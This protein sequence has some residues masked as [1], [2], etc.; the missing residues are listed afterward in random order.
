[1][2]LALDHAPILIIWS[3]ELVSFPTLDGW[4][5]KNNIDTDTYSEERK[6]DTEHPI[7]NWEWSGSLLAVPLQE[8]IHWWNRQIRD[9]NAFETSHRVAR[10]LRDIVWVHEVCQVREWMTDGGQLPIKDTNDSWLRWMEHQ[11][12]DL[13]EAR[14][15]ERA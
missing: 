3:N 8:R 2:R 15:Q 13:V 4:S 9:R 14:S 6:C 7:L 5:D 1:M 11:V 12:I 10:H